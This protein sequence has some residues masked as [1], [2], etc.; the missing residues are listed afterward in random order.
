MRIFDIGI[1]SDAEL[2]KIIGEEKKHHYMITFSEICGQECVVHDINGVVDD[3]TEICR[4]APDHD[5]NHR[6]R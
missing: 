1:F 4:L 6:F 5:G 3:R 2:Q